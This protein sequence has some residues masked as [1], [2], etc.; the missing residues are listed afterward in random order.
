MKF[1]AYFI[2]AVLTLALSGCVSQTKPTSTAINISSE[3]KISQA[4]IAQHNSWQGTPYKLGGENRDGIDC[5]GFTKLTY[6][7]LF[8]IH[9]PRTTKGQAYYGESI[10]P[11][12]LQAGDL[13]L[14]RTDGA[15]QRHVG[16]YVED[17]VFLHAST[18]IGVTLSRLDNPY[19]NK[20]YWKAI[21]PGDMARLHN[22]R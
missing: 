17:G 2:A 19:W 15:K 13:V 7:Q 14:F 4:L 9:L 1:S 12:S 22:Q 5:S 18:S 8:G 20:H 10:H 21:R 11:T 16:I 3:N 6:R